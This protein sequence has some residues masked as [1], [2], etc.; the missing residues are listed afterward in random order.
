[1]GANLGACH[2]SGSMIANLSIRTRLLARG[3]F[4]RKLLTLS[5]GTM[6]GQL[7]F[8]I[9][10]PLITRLYSPAE[11]GL[12]AIFATIASLAGAV[13]AL[14]YEL[15]IPM[16]RSDDEAVAL[17]AGGSLA[18]VV[19][20]IL[21]A[22]LIWAF[23]DAL[24]DALDAQELGQLLWLVPPVIVVWG[25]FHLIG[26]W[27]I[28]QST[29]SINATGNFLQ[30]A[31]A[32]MAQIGLGLASLTGFGLI[33]G[34]VV[35]HVGRL[36]YLARY[37]ARGLGRHIAGFRF[38]LALHL[39]RVNWRFP[40]LVMPSALLQSA[41]QLLPAILVAALYGPALAGLFA[42]SQ[43]IMGMPVRM[44]SE[45]A[46]QVYLGEAG[47]LHGQARLSLFNRTAIRFFL[48]GLVGIMPVL[49][50]GPDLF[51]LLFGEAWREA[52]RIVQVL[53][54]LYLARFVVL[55]ISQTLNIYG[56]QS[57]QLWLSAGHLALLIL[58]FWVG[59]LWSMSALETLLTYSL[60]SCGILCVQLVVAW[61]T[62]KA[63]VDGEERALA[64]GKTG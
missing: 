9:S 49:L 44:L 37:T 52:G 42:L 48:L 31:L 21:L 18:S 63:F 43:R 35:G 10:S 32:A 47:R 64:A 12:F 8:V 41:S 4:N 51:A 50:A 38:R 20:A 54:P 30:A 40:A 3:S 13:S 60:A 59:H 17:V 62:L 24:L 25:C 29:L 28:R 27:S 23:G 26:H 5:S 57:R 46:S 1:M 56:G 58:S 2:P 11:F 36:A 22:G 19:F 33:I 15:S 6:L 34:F 53:A 61:L 45:A 16:A 14:R 7:V 39:L 55:P